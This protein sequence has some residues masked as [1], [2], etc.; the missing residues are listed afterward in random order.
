MQNAYLLLERREEVGRVDSDSKLSVTALKP[1][2][3][4]PCGHGVFFRRLERKTR[5]R[6]WG[7]SSGRRESVIESDGAALGASDKLPDNVT[8]AGRYRHSLTVRPRIDAPWRAVILVSRLPLQ[9]PI[10]IFVAG[11]QGGVVF[12][13]FESVDNENIFGSMKISSMSSVVHP[14]PTIEFLLSL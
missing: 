6:R 11:R 7:G 2:E 10:F 5:N 3:N 14:S 12:L 4:G 8:A 13:P 9:D 1:Q